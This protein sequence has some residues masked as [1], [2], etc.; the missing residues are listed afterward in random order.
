MCYGSLKGTVCRTCADTDHKVEQVARLG[1]M[2]LLNTDLGTL[3]MSGLAP[4]ESPA[5]RDTG[6][7]ELYALEVKLP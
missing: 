1:G 6:T 5:V 3:S 7:Q 4:D 2:K